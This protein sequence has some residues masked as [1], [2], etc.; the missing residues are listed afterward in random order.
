MNN[1]LFLV[2][3]IVSTIILNTIA[4]TFLKM[5][6]DRQSLNLFLLG[7]IFFYGLSTIVYILVLGKFNLSVAY[8]IVIGSTVVATV[9]V[10]SIIFRE[11]VSVTQWIG[12]G[13]T[14]SGISTIALSK[15]N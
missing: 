13:F 3:L 10:G 11:K 5:G 15:V 4:Q 1:Q 12:V 2:L 6:A 8:P 7:G 9:F 14:L